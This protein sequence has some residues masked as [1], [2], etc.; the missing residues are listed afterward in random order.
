MFSKQ[1]LDQR[2]KLNLIQVALPKHG[3]DRLAGALSSE[4]RP[5]DPH[6]NTNQAHELIRRVKM[7]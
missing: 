1:S 2:I 4:G 5:R 3:A 6:E 7:T